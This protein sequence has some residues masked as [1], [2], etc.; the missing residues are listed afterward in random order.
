MSGAEIDT[1]TCRLTRVAT[2][3]G[4]TSPRVGTDKKS[5]HRRVE[6]ERESLQ[7]ASWNVRS[8]LNASGPM[9]TAFARQERERVCVC[10]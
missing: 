8:L 4:V 9:E 3:R 7:L 5:V 6:R 1:A 10:V 2:R